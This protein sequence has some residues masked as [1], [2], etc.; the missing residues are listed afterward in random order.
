MNQEKSV[1]RAL[2]ENDDMFRRTLSAIHLEIMQDMEFL[3]LLEQEFHAKD[4]EA[5]PATTP[6]PKL[7]FHF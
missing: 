3:Q 2:L 5:N 1:F 6:P 7:T 4:L